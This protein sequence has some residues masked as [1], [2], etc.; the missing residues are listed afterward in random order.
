MTY[1]VRDILAQV[2]ANVCGTFEERKPIPYLEEAYLEVMEET[3]RAESKLNDVKAWCEDINGRSAET[4]FAAQLIFQKFFGGSL[5]Y[6]MNVAEEM[7]DSHAIA[8]LEKAG[9]Q[10]AQKNDYHPKPKPKDRPRT[11]KKPRVT[12]R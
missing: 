10:T 7:S 3:F 4:D 1:N 8:A 9:S 12:P 11:H 5:P 2:N 6:R